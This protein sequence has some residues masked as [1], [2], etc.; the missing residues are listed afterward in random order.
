MPQRADVYRILVASPLDCAAERQAVLD[1]VR[2]WNAAHAF[3]REIILEPVLW[4]SH[5]RP[6]MGGRPQ[7]IIN[8]QLVL[9]CDI[10]VG[11]FWTRFGSPT[12]KAASGTV[13]EIEQFREA[14]REVLLYFSNKPIPPSEIDNSQIQAVAA[15]KKQLGSDGL[16]W[17][18]N[19]ENDF[20]RQFS[21]HLGKLMASVSSSVEKSGVVPDDQL[22]V[23]SALELLRD[24]D[25]F[26]WYELIELA[27]RADRFHTEMRASTYEAMRSALDFLHN[28]GQLALK[29][30]EDRTSE[31]GETILKVVAESIS[32]QLRNLAKA[33]DNR[34]ERTGPGPRRSMAIGDEAAILLQEAAKSEDGLIVRSESLEGLDISVQ[35]GRTFLNSGSNARE[36]ARWESAIVEL[37]RRGFLEDKKG[38]GVVYWVTHS[39][40]Q[41]ADSLGAE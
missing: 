1:V 14:G 15:Y 20:Q 7:G 38:Q 17:N 37:V 16:Y 29:I 12:G 41:M 21:R 30:N 40:F 36:E 39:G 2:D 28:D 34:G 11:I 25:T 6:Q 31:S 23:S 10:L 22:G 13:E 19:A 32:P 24:R 18:F 33:L 4:E 5:S 35:G 27:P 9:N 26:F 8:E 3:E